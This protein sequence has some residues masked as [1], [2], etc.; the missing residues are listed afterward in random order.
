[1]VRIQQQATFQ[2]ISL[3]CSPGF[4][5]KRQTWPV[6]LSQNSANIR[7]I[8][9]PWTWTNQ[10]CKWSRYISV[11]NCRP[12]PPCLLRQMPGNPKFDPFHLVKIVPKLEKAT[13]RN[14]KLISSEGGQDTSACFLRQMPGNLSGR[15]D[16]RTCR[17]TVTVGRVD[18]RTH[19][20]IERG[21]FR[22]RT[23]GRPDNPKT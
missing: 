21:Y 23:A 9:R 6:S 2:A 1:M 17:K 3:M 7:K 5:R 8:N 13:D 22:L 14:H 15:T 12:F 18:Q 16:G 19:V 10:F 4:A 20:Q 11:R